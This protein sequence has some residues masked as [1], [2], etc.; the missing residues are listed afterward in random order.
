MQ[1][2]DVTC[3]PN[4]FAETVEAKALCENRP[5][6][7]V[8]IPT[9]NCATYLEKTLESV[10]S[11][12]RGVQNMQILVIDDFSTKDNPK[13]VVDRLGKSRVEFI[14][15]T[16]NVGKA[17]NYQTG[18][19]KSRGRLIHQLHG[20]DLVA[21]GFYKSMEHAFNQFPE[22]GAFFCESEYI[23]AQGNKLGATG[24]ERDTLGI[25]ENWL[26]KLVIAQRI[27]TPSITVRREVYEKLGGFDFRLPYC[28]DWEMWVR[29][30]TNYPFGFNPDVLAKYRT[31]P[32][33]TS[34]QSIISGNRIRVL[35]EAISIIDTYLPKDTLS[36]C[37]TA[38][39]DAVAHSLIRHIPRVIE[40]G[41]LLVWFKLV[42]EI[43]RISRQPRVLYYI[44]V[45]TAKYKRYL[46]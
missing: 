42:W 17:R 24:K 31:Y 19:N 3:H 21:D 22:A 44:F 15:Q 37:K 2:I 1:T 30:A 10:L 13:K 40:D 11:Q 7:S 20:D 38:R 9:H 16:K 12:D 36:R 29:I 5:L 28:E 35:R 43:M 34:S 39:A 6:W 8:L 33:N 41:N 46:T 25:L 14:Q 4:P 45:F 32:E 27:Q 23:D 26:E 18:L